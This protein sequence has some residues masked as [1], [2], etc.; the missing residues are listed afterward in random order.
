MSQFRP[1]VKPAKKY[2]RLLATVITMIIT[3]LVTGSLASAGDIQIFCDEAPPTSF[4]AA[5][6]SVTGFTTEIVHE[7]QKRVGNSSEIKIYPWKRAYMMAIQEPG[8]VLFT[9]SRNPDRENRFHWLIKVTARRSVFWSKKGSTMKITSME[10]AMLVNSIGVLRGGNREK[11]LQ[12]RG[13][14]NLEPVTEEWQNL[15][16]L[17]SGRVDLVFLST[18]EAASIARRTGIPFSRI[19]PEFTVYSNES[20]VVMSRNGTSSETV[21]KWKQ[22][23]R[24]IKAD[25]TFK[26]TGEKWVNHIRNNYGVETEITDDIL[27]FWKH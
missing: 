16:K 21:N 26:K 15:K 7:I 1:P 3:F 18:I 17:L 14:T 22:A 20:Y 27:F 10:D 13:F 25:G 11:Y 6:G 9:A 5:D 8:I 4:R 24:Q 2:H 23:A 12:L 19:E